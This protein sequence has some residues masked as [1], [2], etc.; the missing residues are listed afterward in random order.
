MALNVDAKAP[1]RG[2]MLSE[3][4]RAAMRLGMLPFAW[5]ELMSAP[6]GD[7][8][9]VLALPGLVNGDNSNLV[10]RH[11]LNTLGY[12]AFPWELG[13]NFGPRAIGVEG[14][15]LFE[16]IAAI[17][18]ETGEKVTLVGVSLGGIMARVAAHR[19]PD[20]VRE[21]ITVCSPF[22]G[23]PSAT[24]VW[25]VFELASGQRADDPLVRAFLEEASEPLPVP[26]TA[27]WSRSDGLVNGEVCHEAECDAARSVEVSNGHLL[28]QMSPEVLRAV[29]ETLARAGDQSSSGS[30]A[31]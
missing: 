19:A 31:R 14:E 24:N 10:L 6:R 22:A 23:L 7:G 9:P 17:H 26:A 1:P 27:I 16:R 29:A 21:V 4:P 15:R 20:L 3:W 13:R 12:R 2:V 28:A 8:R 5:R 30:P 18:D 11:Y 25:R